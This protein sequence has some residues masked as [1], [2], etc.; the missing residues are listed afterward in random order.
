MLVTL[1]TENKQNLLI[2]MVSNNRKVYRKYNIPTILN[3]FMSFPFL[4]LVNSKIKGKIMLIL[5]PPYFWYIFLISIFVIFPFQIESRNQVVIILRKDIISFQPLERHIR[6][7]NLYCALNKMEKSGCCS[8]FSQ[9]IRLCRLL[10][11]TLTIFGFFNQ[12]AESRHHDLDNAQYQIS[13]KHNIQLT[14][15]ISNTHGMCG[16]D[17]HFHIFTF[18][19]IDFGTNRAWL[20]RFEESN[21]AVNE[22]QY[23]FISYFIL[24]I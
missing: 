14:S 17:K 22:W 2:E 23:N 15:D 16:H 20:D 21:F 19:N 12:G 24:E 4:D 8:H 13:K 6:L 1:F 3:G 10:L 11:C 7:M 18:V 5:I 9:R